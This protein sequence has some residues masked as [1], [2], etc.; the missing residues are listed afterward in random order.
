MCFWNISITGY[1]SNW[2]SLICVVQRKM[3]RN[4]S[5]AFLV[6]EFH[7]PLHLI[8]CRNFSLSVLMKKTPT[9]TYC[10]SIDSYVLREAPFWNVL[11]PYGLWPNSLR[12]SPSV[13]RGTVEHFLRPNFFHLFFCHCQ[14]EIKSVQTILAASPPPLKQE[15]AH[16]DVE[17]TAPNHNHNGQCPNGNNTFQKGAFLRWAAVELCSGWPCSAS[18]VIRF[19]LF[20][21]N[22]WSYLPQGVK[23]I[24]GNMDPEINKQAN[25]MLF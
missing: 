5:E 18:P 23:K 20:K 2:P 22:L 4:Q 13:K 3:T 10:D 24:E 15:T 19:S 25:V 12:P 6:R 17:R 7:G 14:N 11:F 9:V 21:S 16:L 8:S 1:F